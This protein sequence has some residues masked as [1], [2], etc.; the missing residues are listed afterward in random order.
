MSKQGKLYSMGELCEALAVP[1]YRVEYLIRTGKFDRE[2]RWI[3][4]Y[5]V[6]GEEDLK[7]F[8]KLLK[9]KC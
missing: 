6:F 2:I 9:A 8:R 7:E 1:Y 3:G 4:K 5:R